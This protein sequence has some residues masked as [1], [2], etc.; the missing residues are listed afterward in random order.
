[1]KKTLGQ[2]LVKVDF[3]PSNDSLV[4]DL[5]KDFANLIDKVNNIKQENERSARAREVAISIQHLQTASMF[6]VSSIFA[7][8]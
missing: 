8:D 7:E 3:N 4:N 1:M 5:K 6:A 2:K